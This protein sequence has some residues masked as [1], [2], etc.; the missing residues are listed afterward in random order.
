MSNDDLITMSETL[1]PIELKKI[2]QKKVYEHI[3]KVKSSSKLE[4]AKALNLSLPTVSSSITAFM[5]QGLVE[6]CG[7]YKST[8]GRK[9]QIFRCISLARIS[10]GV[11]VIKEGVRIVATDLYGTILKEDYLEIP[12]I[13]NQEF[14]KNLGLWI[15]SFANNLP[16]H[17]GNFLGVCIALQGLIS[18]DGEIVTYS[19]ILKSTGVRRETYQE[20]IVIPCTLIHDTEAA[21]IAEKWFRN[22]MT[23][24]VYIALNRNFGGVL[25]IDGQIHRSR[26]LSSGIIEHMCLDPNGPICYCGKNGCIETFCSADSLKQAAKMDIVEFFLRVRNNEPI[27]SKLWDKYLRNLALAID[28]IRM[29]VDC[30]FVLGG[31]LLHFMTQSDVDLLIQYVKEQCAFD[32]PSFTLQTSVFGEKSPKIGAAL[33]LV[34][35][36]LK[37]V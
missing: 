15:N 7:E 18:S 8:G 3:Y 35:K 9:A 11:E 17:K 16:Y 29:V 33:S 34:E 31:Y 2:N 27:C 32:T 28:N 20:Y 21:A 25:I 4:I 12:F 14:Y 36:F 19:E 37:T 23:N 24:A 30:E 6:K 22:E 1:T 10:I 5:E 26:E 13:N